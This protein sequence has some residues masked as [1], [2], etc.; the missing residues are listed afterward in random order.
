MFLIILVLFNTSV[1][2]GKCG[3][4]IFKQ[5][6]L[7]KY[8]YAPNTIAQ[9]VQKYG[10]STTT[11]YTKENFTAVSDFG[12]TTGTMTSTVQHFSSW[13]PCSAI[14]G[15]WSLTHQEEYIDQNLDYI[16]QQI[17]VGRGGH[18]ESIGMFFQCSQNQYR[19]LG[20]MMK[21]DFKN[22]SRLDTGK[23]VLGEVN[24]IIRNDSILEKECQTRV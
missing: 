21:R 19:R 18:L 9:N 24:N 10:S 14:D 2:A 6:V 16:K 5:G 11:N 1:F 17:A 13:G 12:V 3:E 7:R 4:S 20:E 22:F 23:H 15:F 8:K